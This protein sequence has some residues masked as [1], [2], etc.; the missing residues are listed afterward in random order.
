V[1]LKYLEL[2]IDPISSENLSQ[3]YELKNLETLDLSGTVDDQSDLNNLHK[4]KKLKKLKVRDEISENILEQLQFGVFNNLEELDASFFN[5]TVESVQAM[6]RITPNLKKI[7]IWCHY[8]ETVN[9]LL[10]NLEHLESLYILY[11]GTWKIPDQVYPNLKKLRVY[12]ANEETHKFSAEQI[13]KAFPNLERLVID[14]CIFE[15]S[16]PSFAKLLSGLKQ[17]KKLSMNITVY[18]D[19]D[20]TFALPC[21]EEYGKDLEI[22]KV[23]VHIY[24]LVSPYL[25]NKKGRFKILKRPNES[26]CLRQ[27]CDYVDDEDPDL[28]CESD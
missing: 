4:L 26:F 11:I 23:E 20:P 17:L 8:S 22:V 1:D 6:K 14:G 7:V 15:V 28:D 9:G 10:E 27:A 13:T 3:I 2:S 25:Y 16:E 18:D 5:V 19:P 12:Y 24:R 21:F